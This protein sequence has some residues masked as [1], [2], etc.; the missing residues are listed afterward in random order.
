MKN[1]QE[2][3]KLKLEGLQPDFPKTFQSVICPS[4]SQNV[5][6][7]NI[8]IQDKIA[9][10]NKCHGIFSFENTIQTFVN[11]K[12]KESVLRPEGIEMFEFHEEIDF[13]IRQPFPSLMILPLTFLP[14]FALLFTA[15]FFKGKVGLVLPAIFWFLTFLSLYYSV[16]RS[17]HKIFLSINDQELSIKWRPKNFN[18][19]KVFDVREIDQLYIKSIHSNYYSVFMIV[20]GID[21]QKHEE[22][23]SSVGSRSKA[24]FLEQEIERYLNIPDRPVPEETV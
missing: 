24:R 10:C 1:Q 21:G 14:L 17:E 23:I 20:N 5:P 9:K 15:I 13:T 2:E 22:L 6:A 3:Y 7:E 16:N 19:D 18:K 12:T 8:N 11:N 4:C